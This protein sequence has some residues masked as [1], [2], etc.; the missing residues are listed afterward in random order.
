[1]KRTFGALKN[2]R[3]SLS[4]ESRIFFTVGFLDLWVLWLYNCVY[5][6]TIFDCEICFF[7]NLL[8]FLFDYI[9]ENVFIPKLKVR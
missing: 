9:S 5:E 2:I 1:M 4:G 8:G 3:D 6:K 7:L